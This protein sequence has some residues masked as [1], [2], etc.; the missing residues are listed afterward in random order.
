MLSR[1]RPNAGQLPTQ[2]IMQRA[3]KRLRLRPLWQQMAVIFTGSFCFGAVVEV[4]ACK[5][6]LYESVVHKKAQRRHEF[7]EFVADLRE[8]VE[9]WT[10]EDQQRAATQRQLDQELARRKAQDAPR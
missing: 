1:N 7:D 2:P 3:I 6:H 5:T 9:E 4:F 8:N 10:K